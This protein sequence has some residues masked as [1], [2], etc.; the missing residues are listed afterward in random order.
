MKAFILIL[1]FFQFGLLFS[2][3]LIVD[4]EGDVIESKNIQMNTDSVRYILF[5][6]SLNIEKVLPLQKIAGIKYENGN[7]FKNKACKLNIDKIITELKRTNKK[8]LHIGFSNSIGFGQ[9][10]YV[11]QPIDHYNYYYADYGY[12]GQA[13]LNVKY[14]V[15]NSF[16][17][18]VGLGYKFDN[19][20]VSNYSYDGHDY[21]AVYYINSAVLPF[22]F[23]ISPGNKFG[24]YAEGG[25]TL[26]VPFSAFYHETYYMSNSKIDKYNSFIDK[27][28]PANVAIAGVIGVHAT[29][30]KKIIIYAGF[31]PSIDFMSPGGVTTKTGFKIGVSY[32]ILPVKK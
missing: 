27:L 19:Y 21:K 31:A 16:G 25:F 14:Y 1:L 17:V 26:V 6:D 32:H 3:D 7:V 13:V 15:T 29:I 22:R 23:F 5:T 12:F 30:K 8:G 10:Y 2:Q 24:F 4:C 11:E 20:F 9:G 28:N 18:K